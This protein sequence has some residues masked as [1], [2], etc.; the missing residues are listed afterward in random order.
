MKVYYYYDKEA[1]VLYFSHG[2]P[3]A[4]DKSQEITDDVVIRLDPKTNKV[5]G[6]TILNFTRRIRRRNVPVSL[7]IHIEL[8]PA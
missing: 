1:D 6:I 8:T 5:R 7:P 2:R 3:S 4:K